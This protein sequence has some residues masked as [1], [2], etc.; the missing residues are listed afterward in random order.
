MSEPPQ[1][2][3]TNWSI[4]VRAGRGQAPGEVR[5]AADEDVAGEAGRGRAA[6]L[7]ARALEVDLERQA[8]VEVADLRAGHEQRVPGGRALARRPSG[9]STRSVRRAVAAVG[10]A[11]GGRFGCSEPASRIALPGRL[12][13]TASYGKRLGRSSSACPRRCA[14][15]GRRRRCWPCARAEALAAARRGARERRA[16]SPP[17]WPKIWPGER[18]ERRRCRRASTAARDVLG[19]FRSGVDALHVDVDVVQQPPA[20]LAAPRAARAVCC[21]S[22]MRSA[23]LVGVNC[24]AGR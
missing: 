22:M 14:R 1:S 19:V 21:A 18:V 6:R 4:S 13:G 5:A 23:C 20:L 12:A 7:D 11:A 15:A 16:S 24:L 17:P 9:S 10:D 3:S 2:V 8:G